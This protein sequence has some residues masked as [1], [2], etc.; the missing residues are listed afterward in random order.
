MNWDTIGREAVQL[1]SHYIQI[2]TINPPGNEHRASVFIGRVLKREGIPYSL[3][4]SAPGRSNLYARLRGDGSKRPIILLSHSDVVPVDREF[5]S[6]DPLSG[7]I[8]DGYI[9]GR[10]ALDMKNV[11]IIELVVFLALHRSKFPLT[12]D[13]ILLVTAD[14]E[15]GGAMGA[16]WFVRHHPDLIR[17]AEFLVN[18]SGKGKIE[19]DALVYS[20]DITEKTPC[21]LRLRAAGEPGHGSRPK[22]NSAVNRLVRALNRLLDY[23]PPVKVSPP[24]DLYFK[25]LAPLQKGER[26]TKFAD[27]ATAV[28]DQAFLADLNHS[29]QHAAVLRNT[30]SITMLRGSPKINIIPQTATAE[31]DCRLLPGESPDRFMA[32]LRRVIDDDG[33]EI[34]PVLTFTNT[35][36]PFDTDFVNAV[37][38]VVSQYHRRTHVIPNVLAGFTDCHFFRDLGIHCYGFSPFIIPDEDLRGIHGNDERISV[39]NMQRGPKMLFEVIER[40]Q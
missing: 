23:T 29:S 16:G 12:R 21:W 5:W 15:A 32:D 10:G 36:S 3:F 20:V 2:D 1:L 17:D 18:E 26:R 4:E 8:K 6:V 34:E 19:H 25:G 38:D 35:A 11:G 24:V 7:L 33:I 39:E 22:P 37:R 9:W 13:V 27:I 28:H 30:V 40:L 14:E 31:L